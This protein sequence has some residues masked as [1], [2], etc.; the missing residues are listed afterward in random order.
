MKPELLP[1][2]F[3]SAEL[4]RLHPALRERL[5]SFLGPGEEILWLGQA[6]TS[7]SIVYRLAVTSVFVGGLC[8]LG[9]WTQESEPVYK[10]FFF[11]EAFLFAI[12]SLIMTYISWK[13][14]QQTVYV[15][16]DQRAIGMV[17]KWRGNSRVFCFHPED[18]A[19]L[20]C[21]ARRSGV[22]CLV[23]IER[24]P[25]PLSWLFS[26][27]DRFYEIRDAR[28]VH[29]LLLDTF[30]PQL[31]PMLSCADP[32][33]RRRAALSLANVG[34]KA[35]IAIPALTDA[36]NSDD[37]VVRRRAA[38]ALGKLGKLAAASVPM[39]RMR[40]FDEDS[41]VVKA[42]L[43][44]LSKIDNSLPEKV[45]TKSRLSRYSLR[46]L[47][48]AIAVLCLLFAWGSF[49]VHR[50]TKQ[51]AAV[52]TLTRKGAFVWYDYEV[53]EDGGIYSEIDAQGRFVDPSPPEPQWLRRVLNVNSRHAV[54]RFGASPTAD[55]C[56]ADLAHFDELPN[57]EILILRCPRVTDAG[58][59]N[60][61]QLKK[62]RYLDLYLTP[63]TDNGLSNIK[64]LTNLEYL[65]LESTEVIEKGF[66]ELAVALPK[67]RIEYT[68]MK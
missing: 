44:A 9:I 41:L 29:H 16:T 33:R 31:L 67:C 56:D 2:P 30:I 55:I 23:W 10:F 66:R 26:Y 17:R 32:D 11:L 68:S 14:A 53:A 52:N 51:Q 35:V 63:I 57:L 47:L 19:K 42:T 5:N 61:G 40:Q 28:Q 15:L 58:L 3:G 45:P 34:D 36:L 48:V 4:K 21:H 18:T 25:G 27:A 64:A 7:F 12:T 60:L 49:K 6:Q 62:L 54:I 38:S 46:S 59:R 43:E 24:V 37:A 20:K 65:R 50:A 22:G 39:L 13:N 1:A 8:S